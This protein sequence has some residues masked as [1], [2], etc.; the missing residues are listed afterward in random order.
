MQQ[1]VGINDVVAGQEGVD[2]DKLIQEFG[3]SKIEDHHLAKIESLSGMPCHR[4]LRRGIF[5]SHRDLG[6]I[7]SKFE[8]GT[9]FYLY[10]GRGPS[11]E[12]LHLGHTIPF[13]FTKYLQEAFDVPLVIQ[14]TDDEKYLYKQ[15]LKL[16][17]TIEMGK[18]N[19]KDIIAFGFNPE[20]TF[21]FSDMDYIQHLY[22]NVLKMQKHV[23]YNQIKGIF[24]VNE[25]SNSGKVA[26]P[27]VQAAPSFSN[28]FPHI[29]GKNTKVPCLIPQAIDQDPYFWMTRDVA[30]RIKYLK[31]SCIHSTFFPAIQGKTGKMSASDKN[32]TIFLTDT[33]N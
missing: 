33:A 8:K 31:P 9:P 4:F 29:F 12:S 3:C 14:I 6:Q 21:I 2:Y 19:I 25:S 10:T 13:I 24:G 15:D 23:T 5:F 30:K 20:K 11:S 7:I 16:E 28:S 32:T 1:Q 17:Q 27:A 22:P 26:F 18:S